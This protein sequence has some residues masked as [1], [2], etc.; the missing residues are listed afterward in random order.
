M[1]RGG[2]LGAG[3]GRQR[4]V[5]RVTRVVAGVAVTRQ[6]RVLARRDGD[7]SGGSDAVL[8]GHPRGGRP[9]RGVGGGAGAAASCLHLRPH[10]RGGEGASGD[11]FFWRGRGL[12][13]PRGPGMLMGGTGG[14]GQRRKNTTYV[15]ATTGRVTSRGCG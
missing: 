14:R 5:E 11:G 4:S 6:G 2:P 7:R 13:G 10:A 9:W 8:N 3:G 15:V 1:D 12:L